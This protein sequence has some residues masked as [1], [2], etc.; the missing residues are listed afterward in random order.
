MDDMGELGAYFLVYSG[1]DPTKV[2][3]DIA[4]DDSN[5]FDPVLGQVAKAW[6]GDNLFSKARLGVLATLS[7]GEDKDFA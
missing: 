4:F 1:I 7:T 5:V 6:R 3:T 2:F